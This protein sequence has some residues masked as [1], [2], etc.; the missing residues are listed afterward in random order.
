M[1]MWVKTEGRGVSEGVGVGVRGEESVRVWVKTEGQGVSEFE[2][3]SSR[4]R[5]RD[6]L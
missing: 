4:V 6:G 1:R 5:G 2:R 3:V